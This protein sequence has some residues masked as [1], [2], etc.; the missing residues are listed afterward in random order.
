MIKYP[1]TNLLYFQPIQ[2]HPPTHEKTLK[3]IRQ[4]ENKK[5]ADLECAFISEALQ[6]IGDVMV[7]VIH[8]SYAEVYTTLLPIIQ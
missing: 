2:D 4:M 3:A 6:S 7:D 5:A 1:Y 8:N